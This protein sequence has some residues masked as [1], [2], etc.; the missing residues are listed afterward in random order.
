MTA[1]TRRQ[2]AATSATP[3][4]GSRIWCRQDVPPGDNAPTG[5]HRSS[6]DT[7]LHRT[8]DDRISAGADRA[9]L[10]LPRVSAALAAR[11]FLPEAGIGQI[12][13]AA[14]RRGTFAVAH[15]GLGR[16]YGGSYTRGTV[17]ASSQFAQSAAF[18]HR[19]PAVRGRRGVDT[20]AARS[21]DGLRARAREDPRARP[22]RDLATRGQRS[23]LGRG[24]R[25][26]RLR[27][28]RDAVAAAATSQRAL[29]A[30]AVAAVRTGP[31]ADRDP[32]GRARAL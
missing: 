31:D 27:A 19:H 17:E 32:H 22:E 30:E 24:R 4:C 14:A 15:I 28:R 11:C 25:V 9:Y 8:D 29:A 7:S 26:P 12:C 16:A 13:S 18:R 20:P 21:R 2:T 10:Q 5:A 6:F 23:G 1:S 3:T